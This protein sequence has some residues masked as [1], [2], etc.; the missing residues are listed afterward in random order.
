MQGIV[1]TLIVIRMALGVSTE[2]AQ[3]MIIASG[4]RFNHGGNV[5]DEAGPNW[6]TTIHSNAERHTV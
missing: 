2:D 5:A 4:L 3:T 1:P 6:P